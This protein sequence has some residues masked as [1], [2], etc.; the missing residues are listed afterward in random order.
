MRRD[1]RNAF[2]RFTPYVRCVLRG[3]DGSGGHLLIR[4]IQIHEEVGEEIE[5]SK[6]TR[7]PDSDEIFTLIFREGKVVLRG[8]LA[9]MFNKSVKLDISLVYGK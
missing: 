4:Q 6:K 7:S 2:Y 5:I 1:V 8:S 3:C 9:D